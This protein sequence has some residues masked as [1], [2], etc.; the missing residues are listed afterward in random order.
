MI[1]LWRDLCGLSVDFNR[2]ECH[3]VAVQPARHKFRLDFEPKPAQV[4]EPSRHAGL[5]RGGCLGDLAERRPA[6]PNHEVVDALHLRAEAL[7]VGNVTLDI[8]DG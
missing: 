6:A 3:S 1:A 4:A 2:R 5:G 7:A 8:P